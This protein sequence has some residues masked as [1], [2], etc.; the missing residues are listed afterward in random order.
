MNDRQI[1]ILVVD[2]EPP[3]TELL[4]MAMRL[5]GWEAL[6]AHD[7]ESAVKQ[8]RAVLPDA[9]V[10]DWMLPDMDG[11]QVLQRLRALS[12][13]LPVL[14][15]TAKDEV[16]DRIAGLTAGADDYVT[17]PFSLEEII[18]RMRGLLRRSGAAQAP[19]DSRLTLGDLVM[20]QDTHE[21][22][23]GGKPVQLTPTEFEL[24]RF[25]L[26]NP[27]RVLSK[28]QILE[29]VWGYDFGGNSNVVELYV[30]YLRRKLGMQLIHT[31]RGAGYVVKPPR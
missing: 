28:T 12:P 21:V 15:L 2:D 27:R 4:T 17:K 13:T 22:W 25:L 31:V 14:M 8:A 11:L 1:H 16:A 26:N 23:R 19:P 30:S 6:P 3:L 10:L 20:D 24:L 18:V 9:V 5:A 29:H 7:G